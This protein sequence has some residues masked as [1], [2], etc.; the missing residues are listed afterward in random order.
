MSTMAAYS[1]SPIPGLV[2]ELLKN[3]LTL[4]ARQLLV[5]TCCCSPLGAKPYDGTVTLESPACDLSS[6][7]NLNILSHLYAESLVCDL[8]V[9]KV[10][11]PLL[12]QTFVRFSITHF[13]YPAHF[14]SPTQNLFLFETPLS[15]THF[16][17]FQ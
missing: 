12:F 17:R 11:K 13:S 7:K 16:R 8:N 6:I 4:L 3:Y 9:C 15:L 10:S 2:P 1:S 5:K 14:N